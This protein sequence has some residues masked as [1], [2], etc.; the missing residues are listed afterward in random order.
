MYKKNILM[1][2]L[3]IALISILVIMPV[4]TSH[5]CCVKSE[6]QLNNQ[7]EESSSLDL[8][9][10]FDLRDVDGINYVSSVKSQSGGTCWAH[11]VMSA[12]EGNLLMTGNW[13]VAGES[14]EP[15]LAEYHL[16]WWNGFNM[17]NNDDD[18]GGEGLEVHMGGD[19]LVASAYLTR[20]EGAVRDVDGQSYDSPPA[21]SNPDYHY[22]YPRDIEWYVAGSDLSNIDLIKRKIMEEGVIGTCMCYSGG[23]IEDYVHYQP[24]SSSQDP[25]HAVAIIGWDDN[26]TTQA[27]EGPGAWLCKNSWSSGWGN[28]GYFWISYYDKHC[29]QYPEMGAVSYQNVEPMRYDQIYYHDYHGWRDTKTDSTEAFNRFIATNDELLKSVSFYTATD[30]V[31]YT[32]KIYDNADGLKS[33]ARTLVESNDITLKNELSSKSGFIDYKGYHT[34]DLDTPVGLTTGD[35]FYIYLYLSKGGQPYDR[36]SEVPVLLYIKS[37]KKGVTVESDSNPQESFYLEDSVWQDM[38]DFDETANFCIKGLT[39]TWVPTEP[40]LECSGDLGWSKTDPGSKIS[41]SF[42]VQNV[43][44]PL[45]CLS[46]EISEYPNWGTWT[47]NPSSGNN[48]KPESE[49]YTVDVSLVAPNQKDQKFNGEIKIINKENEDDFSIIPVSLE[50]SKNKRSVRLLL[51]RLLDQIFDYFPL[52]EKIL[53]NFY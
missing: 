39:N 28:D 24:S 13:K 18:R 35:D 37:Q 27:P 7:G 30:N 16:D 10:S 33:K 12:V 48:L 19:Y 47:F 29:G 9:S 6:K 45:S 49:A 43:G 15:N 36:T 38:Y 17:Y 4:V 50:T 1:Q 32:V 11:G 20:G 21:R 41:G 2:L 25:N 44:E 22:Y 31:E 46:W 8:P 42:T 23:F 40:D 51:S 14:G 26:K 5:S 53:S 3:I 52:L 34:I